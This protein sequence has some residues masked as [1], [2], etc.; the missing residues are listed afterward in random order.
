MGSLSDYAENRILN[1]LFN[2]S[3]AVGSTVY[4]A[5]CTAN[6]TDASTGASCSEVANSNG[7]A[8]KAISFGAASAR[9]ITQDAQVDFDTASGSWGTV[10]GWVLVD[11]GTHS[12]GNV[13]AYGD[14][15]A[16]FAPVSGNTP[17]IASGQVYVEITASSGAGLTT[18]AA[19]GILGHLFDATAF[20]STAGNTFLALL[21]ATCSDAATT[22][23]G[24][25]E[26]TGTSYARKEV[27]EN[28]GASPAWT[29]VS[30]GALSNGAT[31]TFA[32]PGSGGWSQVVG[33]AIVDA[34]SGTSAN[35]IAYDNANVV[36]Q[37]PAAGD[38]VQFASG[39]F[40]VSL[41]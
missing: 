20:T 16:S 30:A 38:T 40:D 14:F 31:A 32:T 6:P 26:V 7:Y 10:L 4:I 5:L 17:R 41:S 1:H 9:R 2:A 13:L 29:T 35:V 3:Q 24:Q 27:N 34:A 39:D 36:D 21:N 8:R 23:A 22:M 11:S 28:G 15:S 18:W 19:N 12:A 37:T 25:T 33:V